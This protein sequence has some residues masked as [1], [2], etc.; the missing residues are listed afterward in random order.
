MSLHVRHIRALLAHRLLL[1]NLQ[2]RSNYRLKFHV[3]PPFVLFG[4]VL[5][6]VLRRHRMAKT[7]L[8]TPVNFIQIEL[9]ELF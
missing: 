4:E 9:V 5:A 6:K 1:G 2:I 7:V 3:I 8:Q